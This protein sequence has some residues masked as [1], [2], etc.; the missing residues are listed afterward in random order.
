MLSNL[1]A[2]PIVILDLVQD[3]VGGGFWR[4]SL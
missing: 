3:L 1:K 4:T 2:L